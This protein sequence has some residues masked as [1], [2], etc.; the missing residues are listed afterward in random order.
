[1][2]FA[3]QCFLAENVEEKRLALRSTHLRYLEA[4]KD[5]IYCGGPTVDLKGKPE[6]MLIILDAS[7]LA[8]AEAFMQKEPYN[9]SGVFKQITIRE[10]R[11]VLPE[12]QPGALL[13]EISHT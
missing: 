12:S 4:N 10:W 13:H 7:D 2:H 11:Q 1:M 5:H 8:A 9:Q 6:T 3:I